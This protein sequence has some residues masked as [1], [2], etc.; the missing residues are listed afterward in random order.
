MIRVLSFLVALAVV[1]PLGQG[2]TPSLEVS[3]QESEWLDRVHEQAYDALMPLTAPGLRAAYRRG[4][5]SG[6]LERYFAISLADRPSTGFEA[7]VV[8]PIGAS[9]DD[10]LLRQF[11]RDVRASFESILLQ[12]TVRRFTAKSTACPAIIG[13]MSALSKLSLSLQDDGV[14]RLDTTWHRFVIGFASGQVDAQIT[15]DRHPLVG[16]ATTTYDALLACAK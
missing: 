8:T 1:T 10:Q 14:I 13:Q 16:W 7:T 2:R 3:R 15:D 9:I 11:R 5:R 12:V 6:E 4:E